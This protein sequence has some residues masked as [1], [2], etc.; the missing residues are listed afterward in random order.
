VGRLKGVPR[1]TPKQHQS[2]EEE[3]QEQEDMKG[4]TI[5]ST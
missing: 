1:K 3:E 5:L 4:H 2:K